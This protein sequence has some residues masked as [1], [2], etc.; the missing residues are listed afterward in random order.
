MSDSGTSGTKNGCAGAGSGSAS[1]FPGAGGGSDSSDWAPASGAHT[2]ANAA[3][4]AAA[5]RSCVRVVFMVVVCL[6]FVRICS[7]H[8]DRPHL[9]GALVNHDGGKVARLLNRQ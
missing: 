2:N 6:A 8:L 3:A 5:R 7:A 9:F 4:S 1:N